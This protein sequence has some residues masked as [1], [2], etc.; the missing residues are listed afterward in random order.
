MRNISTTI[1]L[2]LVICTSLL[3]VFSCRK[4][5]PNAERSD[6]IRVYDSADSK[7]PIDSAW[8]SVSGGTFT[9]YIRSSVEFVARWQSED[10]TWAR[11]GAPVKISDGLWSIDVTVQP[12]SE[13]TPE[14]RN[15]VVTGLY[16]R[17]YGV[18]MLGVQGRFLG[19]F[20]V[21]EQGLR[22]RI[23]SDFS[24]LYGSEDP[25]D[26]YKNL[27][28]SLW[29]SAQKGY[30]FSST[31]IDGE[32]DRWVYSK[33]GYV[34]LGNDY[35]AGADLIT[36]R[37]PDFQH[38]TL[39]VVSFR[40]VAQN[41]GPLPDFTGG[42][43]PIVP[44]KSG[45]KKADGSEDDNTLTVK[46]TGGGFIRDLVQSGGTSISFELPT[47]DRN[48]VG[49][50]SDMFD[51][52]SFLVFIEGTES[53]PITVNTAIHFEAGSMKGSDG[54][55]CSRVFLDDIFVYR[56]DLLYDEDLFPLNGGKSGLDTITGG[57]ANE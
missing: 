21:I 3:S 24:W 30:G 47:Y 48:S 38:D 26:N 57:Q 39:L 46:V 29:T 1:K 23:A 9:Y 17:R 42:T 31:L 45:L 15:G 35:G 12:V 43:E 54:G 52:G 10:Q 22:N 19:K 5:D 55:Q 18:L 20:F 37:C 13:R 36:P 41:G 6:L 7:T 8:V 51:K 2:C 16:T 53:N 4:Q 14:S 49:F 40:A 34:K 11:I 56:Q 33:Q 50:P 25:N 27:P 44:M 32:E 28:M